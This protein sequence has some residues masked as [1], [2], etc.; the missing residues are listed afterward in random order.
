MVLSPALMDYAENIWRRFP[1][2]FIALGLPQLEDLFE[3]NE[4][5]W[6]YRVVDTRAEKVVEIVLPRR[7]AQELEDVADSS[8]AEEMQNHAPWPT[9]SKAA[10]MS[11]EAPTKVSKQQG[12]VDKLA[13][14][15]GKL[16]LD[17]NN[18]R[19]NIQES[20]SREVQAQASHM[21]D[22]QPRHPRAKS[23]HQMPHA[24]FLE[25]LGRT[26][27]RRN[28]A[29]EEGEGREEKSSPTESVV[30]WTSS[31]AARRGFNVGTMDLHAVSQNRDRGC[32]KRAPKFDHKYAPD[33]GESDG[34]NLR[35][36]DHDLKKGDKVRSMK[37][38]RERSV[39]ELERV[40]AADLGEAESSMG[41]TASQPSVASEASSPG[42]EL[43]RLARRRRTASLT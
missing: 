10:Q 20:V 9:V 1:E 32:V 35:I 14:R 34:A 15:M 31:L 11:R 33:D 39:S 7:K 26:G 17:V 37:G 22:G 4:G 42:A 23:E 19:K 40:E 43:S 16:K 36:Q 13:A 21:H 30:S 2:A 25:A 5:S 8:E 38:P 29:N 18:L 12:V 6:C 27:K 41:V 3:L 28:E 24:G